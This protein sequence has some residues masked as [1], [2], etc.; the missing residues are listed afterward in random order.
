MA[1]VLVA[2]GAGYIG[3]HVAKALAGAGHVPVTYDSLVGGHRDFV[4]WGPLVQA[5]IGD[6][7]AVAQTLASHAIDAAIL[8]A[9]FIEVGES[10]RDPLKYYA[11]NV[12]KTCAFLDVLVAAG[13]NALVFSSSAA[14]Y[15]EPEVTPIPETHPT[16]PVNPYGRTKLMVETMIRDIAAVGPM[17]AYSLRYFNAAGA[18]RD[19]EIGEDHRP[20]THLIPRACLALLGHVPPLEI[21][22]DDY[23]TADGTAVRDYV[24][25][26]DLASAHVLAVEALLSGDPGGVANLGA[27]NG[28]SVLDI[29]GALKRES[30]RAVP[31]SFAPRRSGDPAVLVADPG[32]T[33][34]RLGW[35]AQY[36]HIDDIAGTAWAWHRDRH[37][38]RH[39]PASA[40]MVLEGT[41]HA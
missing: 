10:V 38:N 41:R 7:G 16:N 33:G 5:D 8:L 13:V 9:G 34:H 27:G 14:V 4:K 20:E 30:G 40:S 25:V 29:L 39:Q 6:R 2:G 32:N 11:N 15:G 18:D 35:R 36:S 22:G 19:C 28:H 17:C 23:P 37:G 21:Y 3:A 12:A 26:E 31:Y 1:N 24:H